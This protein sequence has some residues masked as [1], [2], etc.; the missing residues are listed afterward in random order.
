M[1]TK[2]KRPV[3]IYKKKETSYICMMGVGH[4]REN[5]SKSLGLGEKKVSDT[6]LISGSGRRDNWDG[7]SV[8]NI[9]AQPDSGLV[10][11]GMR[12]EI[13]VRES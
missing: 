3:W 4:T 7:D 1:E 6:A 8:Q 2:E 12:G 9:T 10:G 13:R 5:S 11:D